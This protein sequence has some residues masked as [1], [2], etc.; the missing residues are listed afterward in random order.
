MY[1]ITVYCNTLLH[2]VVDRKQVS[3]PVENPKHFPLFQSKV[4]VDPKPVFSPQSTSSSFPLLT[5]GS[6]DRSTSVQLPR[7]N[8]KSF[9]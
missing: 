3:F 4:I 9:V 6:E 1:T 7:T 5:G 8:S 2:A